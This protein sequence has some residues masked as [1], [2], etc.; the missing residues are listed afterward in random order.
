MVL[1]VRFLQFLDLAF[2]VLLLMGTAASSVAVVDALWFIDVVPSKHFVDVTHE[3]VAVS[4]F[5]FGGVTANMS[6]LG[7][8]AERRRAHTVRLLGCGSGHVVG[9]F[10]GFVF[11]GG[12]I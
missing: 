11:S 8:A 5:V 10:D 6:L 1:W 2:K 3:V 7:P 4:P 12:I 9:S